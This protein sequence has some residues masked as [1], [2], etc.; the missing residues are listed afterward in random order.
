MK[1]IRLLL[2]ISLLLSLGTLA[3]LIYQTNHKKRL[4][5]EDLIEISDIKYGLFNVDE[6]RDIV[7]EIIAKKIDELEVQGKDKVKLEKKI[8]D[9]LHDV[10]H[11]FEKDYY[12]KNRDSFSGIIK[13]IGASAFDIF[14]SMKIRIPEFSKQIV[15]F[16]DDPE[17]KKN[18]KAYITAKINEYAENTFSE[19]D[20]SAHNAVLKKYPWGDRPATIAG[21]RTLLND[22]QEQSNLYKY[23]LAVI[24]VITAVFIF[25][26]QVFSKMEFILLTLVCL[27]F[28]VLGLTLP[29][30]E[31]D[32]RIS[33]FKISLLGEQINFQQQ[34]IY[35]KSK[36]IIEVIQLM[37]QQGGFDLLMVGLLVFIFSVL[38]PLSKLITSVCMVLLPRIKSNKIALFL[39]YKTGKWSMAD[40]M[41]VAIFMAYIGFSGILTEQLSQ[42]EG[43]SSKVE[44][45]TT[46]Q[47]SIQIGFFAFTAFALLSLL[48]NKRS[49]KTLA[50]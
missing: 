46:N 38:F 1:N 29:M 2:I 13:N 3:V 48:L 9:F 24:A 39:V 23:I 20:Y 35:Y 31:I 27:L 16:L 45:L 40:V 17:N 11:D 30:I 41:V 43:L 32:A 14:G 49:Q 47:S 18:L 8:T 10:I 6:W 33:D 25:L 42:I 15:E 26:A 22:I 7:S 12:D 44:V 36:S 5:K 34:V 37:I 19:V 21:L 50:P 28:L 4:I